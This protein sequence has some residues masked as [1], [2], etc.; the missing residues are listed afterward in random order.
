MNLTFIAGIR[1]GSGK[2]MPW[3]DKV[4]RTISVLRSP[5]STYGMSFGI[6]DSIQCH[7]F[8]GGVMGREVGVVELVHGT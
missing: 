1:T 4:T 2:I 6:K 5:R 8:L 7:L 3:H